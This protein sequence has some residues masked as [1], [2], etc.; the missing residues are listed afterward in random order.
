MLDPER[1]LVTGGTGSKPPTG[2][3]EG[4]GVYVRGAG[5]TL[6]GLKGVSGDGSRT[7]FICAK[8]EPGNLKFF[9]KDPEALLPV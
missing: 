9:E 3:S 5:E 1:I 8:G 2:S 4:L 6:L 7:W